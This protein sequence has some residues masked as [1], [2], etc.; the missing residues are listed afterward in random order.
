MYSGHFFR[1]RVSIILVCLI[2]LV[3]ARDIWNTGK[4]PFLPS[5]QDTTPPTQAVPGNGA[6]QP[7]RPIDQNSDALSSQEA[8]LQSFCAMKENTN[9]PWCLA[10]R[11]LPDTAIGKQTHSE[12][13]VNPDM[14]PQA[15]SFVLQPSGTLLAGDMLLNPGIG[16]ESIPSG[17]EKGLQP[18]AGSPPAWWGQTQNCSNGS[19]NCAPG[20]N[21]YHVPEPGSLALILSVA[22][23]A[24]AAKLRS[25]C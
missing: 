19:A 13:A 3:T 18:L 10:L 14:F 22:A 9:L 24:M 4:L 20:S 6:K 7:N 2:A 17:Q 12:L 15:S 25:L 16:T 1:H 5:A 21:E 23:I 8:L 11:P